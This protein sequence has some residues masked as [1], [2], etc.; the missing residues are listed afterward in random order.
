MYTFR[1]MIM[2]ELSPVS[3]G[4]CTAQPGDYLGTIMLSGDIAGHCT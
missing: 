2:L 3:G 1:K 4:N